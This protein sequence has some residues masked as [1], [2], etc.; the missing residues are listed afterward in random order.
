MKSVKTKIFPG[1]SPV[2]NF[3]KGSSLSLYA[4]CVCGGHGVDPQ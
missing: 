3:D 4:W 1:G 2:Y